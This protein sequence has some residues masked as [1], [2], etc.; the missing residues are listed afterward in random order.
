MLIY[1]LGF[2][3]NSYRPHW[4][5]LD[6]ITMSKK[7]PG[8]Q[9]LGFGFGFVFMAYHAV[10]RYAGAFF[11]QQG[12]LGMGLL[13]LTVAYFFLLIGDFLSPIVIS[14]LGTRKS[15]VAAGFFYFLW[16]LSMTTKVSAL[17]IP[18]SAL[19]GLSAAVLWNSMA[20]NVIGVSI[21]NG[22]PERIP[23]NFG[24]VLT[25]YGL[26]A[27]IGL[28]STSFLQSFLSVSLQHV[29]LILAPLVLVGLTFFLRAKSVEDD[30][31]PVGASEILT[32]Y[33]NPTILRL[34]TVSVTTFL[35][36]G[37]L[38]TVVPLQIQAVLGAESIGILSS[39]AFLV[40]AF[41]YFSGA[42]IERLGRNPL[43]ITSYVC[44]LVGLI[45]LLSLSE[46]SV[47][48]VTG[49]LLIGF[50]FAFL[51]VIMFTLS[52]CSPEHKHLVS[53]AVFTSADDLAIFLVLASSITLNALGLPLG[54]LY[55]G[56]LIFLLISALVI[57]PL[58]QGEG[59]DLEE[60]SRRLEKDFPMGVN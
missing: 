6:L 7:T 34:A 11:G 10:E 17:M 43:L 16:I 52:E 25:L 38:V 28:L 31:P 27:A 23:S 12:T 1:L 56:T 50:S 60:A 36:F 26:G 24:I 55:V 40:L 57:A 21:E 35:V 48:V 46:Q 20:A 53:L 33:K 3:I 49:A 8:I 41:C 51:F 54:Y 45:L 58:F 22:Q 37:L 4:V 59:R 5:E 19:A 18:A 47:A 9:V 30:T 14:R 44:L 39:G 2:N 32:M 15:M 13:V 42:L 29:F